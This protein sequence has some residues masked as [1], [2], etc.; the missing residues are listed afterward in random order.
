MSVVSSVV[1]IFGVMND[2]RSKLKPNLVKCRGVGRNF[3]GGVPI[4]I[5]RSKVQGSGGAAP[6]GCGEGS[7]FVII[8]FCLKFVITQFKDSVILYNTLDIHRK[9]LLCSVW[10]LLYLR[11]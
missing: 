6:S 11:C 4:P 9:L 10:L 2:C 7:D 3:S 1:R 8:T 5:S